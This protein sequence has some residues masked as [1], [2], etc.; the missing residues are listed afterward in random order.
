MFY[1]LSYIYE[2]QILYSSRVFLPNYC[3][4]DSFFPSR[5]IRKFLTT[6]MIVYL[7]R[8]TQSSTAMKASIVWNMKREDQQDATIRCLLLTSASTC[9]GQ[10]YAHLQENKGR[11]TAFD[12]LLWFCCMWLVAVVGALSCRTWPRQ[13]PTTAT[14]HIQQNQNNTPNAVT[15]PLIS[16]RWA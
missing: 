10:N 13:R 4:H 9:F 16:W 15:G 14:N 7:S 2:S 12:V 6:L 5:S 1:Y 11:V 8:I 3:A